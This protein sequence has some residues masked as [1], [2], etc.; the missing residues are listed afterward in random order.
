[1]GRTDIVDKALSKDGG[2]GSYLGM[3]AS[4]KPPYMNTGVSFRFTALMT[5]ITT[6]SNLHQIATLHCRL[7]ALRK[8]LSYID[9]NSRRT[10]II[11]V[12]LPIT[13]ILL[14]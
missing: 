5:A 3:K 8:Y 4:L 12:C 11:F 10:K 7:E 2:R 9:V 14:I 6:P 13:A 1:M